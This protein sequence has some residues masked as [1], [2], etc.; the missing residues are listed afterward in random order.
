MIEEKEMRN[1]ISSDEPS[2]SEDL[3]TTNQPDDSSS[4]GGTKRLR[5]IAGTSRR[6]LFFGK[7]KAEMLA[8]LSLLKD[9]IQKVIPM[10]ELEHHWSDIV[11]DSDKLSKHACEQQEA[12]WEFV[13]TEHRYLL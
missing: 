9:E 10:F 6:S 13:T 3:P 12:I 4:V 1:D 7:D 8:R 11:R 5:N 2:C